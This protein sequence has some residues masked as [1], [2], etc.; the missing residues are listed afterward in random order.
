MSPII[1][2]K[3]EQTVSE[4]LALADI[5]INGPRPW[6]IQVHS[7]EFYNHLLCNGSLALGESYMA[8]WWDA[9]ALDQVFFRILRSGLEQK[10]RKSR[11]AILCGIKAT[12]S[13]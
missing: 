1:K 11:A 2:D 6:D 13:N 10:L 4:V 3:A 9:A 12:L 7:P 5:S 8:G